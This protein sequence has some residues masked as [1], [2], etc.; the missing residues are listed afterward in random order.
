M[1]RAHP[2]APWADADGRVAATRG[3][4]HLAL[5]GRIEQD[6]A[7]GAVGKTILGIPRRAA[8][9]RTFRPSAS[10]R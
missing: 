8:D 4:R 7:L 9:I 2:A 10:H 3:H 6:I 1:A 5:L